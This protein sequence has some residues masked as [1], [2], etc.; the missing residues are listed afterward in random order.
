MSTLRAA[1]SRHLGTHCGSRPNVRNTLPLYR[2][3][4]PPC[5]HYGSPVTPKS[6]GTSTFKLALIGA[7]IGAASGTAYSIYGNWRDKNSHMEHERIPP[8]VLRKLPDVRITKKYVNPLDDSDLN[9]ILFQYQTCP[10]CCKV[11]AF[12]DYMGISYSVVEVDAVLRQDIKWSD[13]KK[14]PMILVQQGDGRYIQMTDSSAIISLLASYL[15]DKDTDIGY[16][17]S[18]YPAISFFDDDS[19]KRLDILNKYFLMYQDKTPKNV[20]QDMQEN[21]RKWRTWADSHL[22]HLISPNCYRTLAEA[23]ET[24]EWFSKAGEWDIYFPKWERNLMVNVGAVAMWGISKML[25]R[26]HG[27]SDDVRSHIYDALNKWTNELE[28]RK[29]KFMGGKQP[30]LADL[31]VFGVLNSMEG[32]EAFGDCMKNTKIGVWYTNVRELVDKNR[33]DLIRRTDLVPLHA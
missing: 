25:K 29:Q 15:N 6:Q 4:G 2:S 26:R 18:F 20:T 10:F 33:G 12:L 7:G 17:A 24:F 9:I 27:L 32:C 19:K 22:V 31:A 28:K 11:R 16:L 30:N 3:F 1:I 23:R 13:Q 8:K 21:E 5:R 14:V